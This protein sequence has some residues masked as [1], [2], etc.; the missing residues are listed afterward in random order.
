MNEDQKNA[1]RELI[2][3]EFAGTAPPGAPPVASSQPA[4]AP[5][6]NNEPTYPPEVPLDEYEALMVEALT[7]RVEAAE[8]TQTLLSKERVSVG[9]MKHKLLERCVKRLNI[10]V[11]QYNIL[12]DSGTKMIKIEKRG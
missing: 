4:Q 5:V 12:I 8:K 7:W 11:N 2:A 6:H 1:V 10:D 3:A 9:E